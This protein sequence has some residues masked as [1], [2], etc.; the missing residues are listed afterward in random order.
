M[1]S[2]AF[3]IATGER[4]RL[5]HAICFRRRNVTPREARFAFL[6]YIRRYGILVSSLGMRQSCGNLVVEHK[7]CNRSRV[8]GS[9]CDRSI[10]VHSPWTWTAQK[11]ERRSGKLCSLTRRCSVKKP[12]RRERIVHQGTADHRGFRAITQN[13]GAGR[14]GSEFARHGP[15]PRR[16][17]RGE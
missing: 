14:G 13:L 9:V 6:S 7:V 4:C 8:F 3:A 5:E 12:T 17:I 1:N 16:G 10:T 15:T 2:G 11:H